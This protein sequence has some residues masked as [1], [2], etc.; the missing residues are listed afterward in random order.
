MRTS[1]AGHTMSIAIQM[2]N[3]AVRRESVGSVNAARCARYRP[4][5][6][7]SNRKYVG[8]ENRFARTIPNRYPHT[9]S[10]NTPVPTER[11]PAKYVMPNGGIIKKKKGAL[12]SLRFL[13]DHENVLG[14][15]P[16]K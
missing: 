14:K 8:I 6:A 2:R 11:L 4:R 5:S 10:A 13:S 7:T 3:A 12:S 9:S 1:S 16:W 15:S